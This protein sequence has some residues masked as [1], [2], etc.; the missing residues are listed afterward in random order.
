MQ[1]R[2]NGCDIYERESWEKHLI[3]ITQHTTQPPMLRKRSNDWKQLS[4]P[5]R[6]ISMGLRFCTCVYVV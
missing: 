5:S 3:Y 1:I 4:R 6:K 2:Q